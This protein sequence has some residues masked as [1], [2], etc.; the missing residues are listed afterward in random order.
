M[1][2]RCLLVFKTLKKGVG[3]LRI[4]LHAPKSVVSR[5]ADLKIKV[6]S[7]DRLIPSSTIWLKNRRL[8]NSSSAEASYRFCFNS[9][10]SWERLLGVIH[11]FYVNSQL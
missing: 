4:P 8:A 5:I 6:K 2:I 9:V 1:H 7:K 3:G 11:S 10:G